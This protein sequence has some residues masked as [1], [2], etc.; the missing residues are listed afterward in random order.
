[1]S[2]FDAYARYYD[3]LYRDKDYAQ[4]VDFV[5]QLLQTHAP[6]AQHL[7]ELGSGTGR[8]AEHLAERGYHI[9]GIERSAEM[10]A[11]CS[12]RQAHQPS[13]IAQR[14]SFLQGDLRE[15][16]LD[17]TFDT[18]LSLFH[19]ISYQ[20]SNADL[21]AAFKTVTL[22]LK[23][24]GVF[25]FDAW[26][27]PAVLHDLPQVR[28]KRLHDDDLAIT[29]IAEPV[30]HVNDNIVDVNYQILLQ[31][32]GQNTCQELRELHRMRYLFTPEVESLLAQAGLKLVGCGEWLRDRPP[33]LDTWGVYFVAVKP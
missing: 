19:V 12:Q 11:R 5:Y 18:V 30:L 13:A 21:A 7:L 20:T 3:L 26:Y 25:I 22:H 17:Q 14:L 16:R 24:G 23:P 15:V 33:S 9:T 32:V 2:V 6:T 31:P 8:H 28:V 27:G 10:L 4:E 29:R 1:M